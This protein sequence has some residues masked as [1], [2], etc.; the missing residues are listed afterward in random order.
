MPA[1]TSTCRSALVA[2]GLA[3]TNSITIKTSSD[4]HPNGPGRGSLWETHGTKLSDTIE[5]AT[6]KYVVAQWPALK[7]Q[8]WF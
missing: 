1:E 4:I 3:S 2:T 5:L 7:F 8:D 6:Q